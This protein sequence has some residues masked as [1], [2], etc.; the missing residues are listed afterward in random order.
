MVMSM[1]ERF[2]KNPWGEIC[3]VV[4]RDGLKALIPWSAKTIMEPG[5]VDA[6]LDDMGVGEEGSE[7]DL[8]TR[9]AV[10]KYCVERLEEAAVHGD[11]L[12]Y[13]ASE[14]E[15]MAWAFVYGY[16]AATKKYRDATAK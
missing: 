15:T 8:E 13:E 11:G 1:K 16:E 9:E 5:M 14:M 6:L 2:C 3:V 10:R 7:H 12:E 4:D